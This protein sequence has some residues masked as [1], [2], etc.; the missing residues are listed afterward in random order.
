MRT[1]THR[2]VYERQLVQLTHV[3]QTLQVAELA[4]FVVGHEQLVQV[5]QALN[6]DQVAQTILFYVQLGQSRRLAYKRDFTNVFYL[7]LVE[8]QFAQIAQRL[9]SFN[10]GNVVS[11][12][13]KKKTT[14]QIKKLKR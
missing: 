1:T 7:V 5:F 14:V 4:D 2:I 11:F 6:V 10:S 3:T 12:T 13:T 9:N 8:H